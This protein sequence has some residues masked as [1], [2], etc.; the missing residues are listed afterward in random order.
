MLYG[1]TVVVVRQGV[2][3]GAGS[4]GG[5]R[6]CPHAFDRFG[7]ITCM[8]E[9]GVAESEDLSGEEGPAPV[10]S[11]FLEALVADGVVTRVVADR[12]RRIQ[13][14]SADRLPPVLLKLGLLSEEDLAAQL[15]EYSG[16]DR[17]NASDIPATR[18]D[19]PDLNASLFRTYA[20]VPIR[21]VEGLLDV[22]CWDATDA[23]G[24]RALEFATGLRVRRFVGTKS[25]LEQ[26]ALA[27]YPIV[28]DE[29]R[30]E[31][32][33]DEL[34]EEEEFSRLKDLAS[35]APIIR[36]VQRVIDEAV[37]ARASDI[38]FETSESS[39]LIRLRMD[40]MLLEFE[41]HPK[42]W[43]APIVSRV[44]VM[45]GLNIAERRLPQ[46]GR[47]RVTVQGKDIDFRVA[48]SPTLHGESLVLRILDKQDIQ[49]D[50][51]AL[52]F[53]SEITERVA[54]A[55]RRPHG[56]VL[57]TGP[58]GSGKTTTLY[59][60]LSLINRPDRKI[61]TVEDPVEYVLAGVNQVPIRPQIGLTFAQ[62]LRSFLRQDP[63]VL[64]VGEIRDRETA[65]TAVQ[66]SLTGHLLLSTL[67]T[68]SAAGAITRLLDMGID[69]FLLTSTLHLILGQRLVRCLCMKCREPYSPSEEILHRYG[70]IA[71][72]QEVW[73][74]A[75]G[76]AEC[77]ETGYRGR[78]TV[79]EALPMSEAVRAAVLRR[80]DSHAIER[81]ASGEGM[82]TLMQHGLDR[83]R[84]GKTSLEEVVRVTSLT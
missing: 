79:L 71:G 26:A 60:A 24:P 51:D 52:G 40:G 21:S 48:T 78:T 74:R 18:V 19:L 30:D 41:R 56:I 69:D 53:P 17:L 8:R 83:V 57:V 33:A 42:S 61:L 27:L 59:A 5:A 25:Q 39:L 3:V 76:C 4:D 38:H 45:A 70:V 80:E 12:V 77:R 84:N 49:L 35:D 22:A 73:Y 13:A 66:A 6:R 23:Y 64:M 9:I 65:E 34:G 10:Q 2:R 54:D 32:P 50:F 46:D 16:C 44:K 31:L 72:G 37:R 20:L 67:H 7:Y 11:S 28:G 82:L 14:E 36:L 1:L 47:I 58:T 81:I 55:V 15:A 43:G 62:A 63:D 68:N 75:T 29:K